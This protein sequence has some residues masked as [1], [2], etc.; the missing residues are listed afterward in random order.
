[1]D[2]VNDYVVSPRIGRNKRTRKCVAANEHPGALN[3]FNDR[4]ALKFCL[5]PLTLTCTAM[6]DSAPLL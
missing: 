6:N 4:C 1:V 3:S 2:L 5:D